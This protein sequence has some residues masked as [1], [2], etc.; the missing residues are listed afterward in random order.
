[1]IDVA[2]I[3]LSSVFAHF[4]TTYRV[5]CQKKES[6]FEKSMF[7][8]YRLNSLPTVHLMQPLYQLFVQ[9]NGPLL[10]KLLIL[11]LRKRFSVRPLKEDASSCINDIF[12]RVNNSTARSL[13]NDEVILRLP[14]L[15]LQGGG[16]RM[17][18][19]PRRQA[20]EQSWY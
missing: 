15:K 3:E 6:P 17:L 14:F 18:L 20:L 11:N 4:V 19:V 8:E 12:T 16:G 5:W 13:R 2:Y 1:M 9:F 10:G 7:S